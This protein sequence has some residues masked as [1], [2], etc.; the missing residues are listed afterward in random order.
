MSFSFSLSLSR[1][2]LSPPISRR[3]HLRAAHT[4]GRGRVGCRRR[5][6]DLSPDIIAA[7]V[8]RSLPCD[9][10]ARCARSMP[11]LPARH[12]GR[13]CVIS[14]GLTTRLRHRFIFPNSDQPPELRS[15]LLPPPADH[16]RRAS[17]ANPSDQ[18]DLLDLEIVVELLVRGNSP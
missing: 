11:L 7:V 18:R 1:V 12:S 6:A 9:F 15:P 16:L 10:L 8:L 13:H 3:S 2:S 14:T 5:R 17:P 4:S